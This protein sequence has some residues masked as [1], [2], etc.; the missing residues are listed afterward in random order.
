MEDET[1]VA[2]DIKAKLEFLGYEVT[3]LAS[4]GPEALEMIHKESPDLAI[5]DIVLKGAMDG[6]EVARKMRR[7]FNIPF[8]YLTALSDPNTIERAKVTEPFGY[9][10]K[11]FEQNELLAAIEMAL[12]KHKMESKIRESEEKYRNLFKNAVEG[13]FQTTTEGR[14]LAANP[15]MARMLGYVSPEDLIANRTDIARQGYVLPEKREE[16]MVLLEKFGEVRGFEL[17]AYRQDRSIVWLSENVRLVRDKQGKILFYEGTAQ[18]ISERKRAEE[19]LRAQ[20]DLALTVGKAETFEEGMRSCL[21]TAISI[22]EMDCGGVYLRDESSG[23]LDLVVHQGLSSEFIARASHYEKDEPNTQ[24][25]MAGKPVYTEHLRLGVPLDEVKRQEGLRAIALIPILHEDR[26]IGCMNI[27]SH[28]L[29]EVPVF[30]RDV[31]ETIAAQVSNAIVRLQIKDALSKSE[32]R[33]KEL[34]DYAPVAYHILN[35]EGIIIRAN[36]TEATM[37]GYQVQEMVGKSIFDFILPEHRD[38]AQKR[39]RQKIQGRAV[40]RAENR[41][42]IRKDGSQIFVVIDDVLERDSQGII[43]GIKSTMVDITERKRAEL[44]YKAIVNT[45]MD[46]FWITDIRGRFLDV[47]ET[48]CRLIGYSREE[49]LKMKISDVEAEEKPE[50]T[51]RRI[52]KIMKVGGDRFVTRHRRKDG[53]VID[54]EVSVNYNRENR[55]KLFVFLRDITQRKQMEEALAKYIGELQQ[56]SKKMISV[57]EAERLNISH[58]LHDEMGQ[59]LTMLRLNIASLRDILAPEHIGEIKKKIADADALTEKL[60]GQIHEL[61][62]DLRPHMLDDLGLVPTLRWY[63]DRMSRRLNIRILFTSKN[64]RKRLDSE[65]S[66]AIFRIIQEAMT[67]V[68]KYARAK[69]VRI[70]LVQKQKVIEA[71]IEDDGCGFDQKK[72]EKRKS[73]ARGIGLFSMKE[74]AAL[75]NGECTI[76]SQ[77]GKGTRIHIRIP[78]RKA[79]EKN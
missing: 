44:E 31:L 23:A 48:Y 19:L 67:N 39:F 25:V 37:L 15:A 47:N 60:L 70:R 10:I 54:I 13:I 73:P 55:D 79:G 5:I 49:L 41:V 26:V 14:F 75:L 34:W 21:E 43:T 53:K 76:E 61:T 4:T 28:T 51:A 69:K 74:R 27:S 36:Q 66:T 6:I 78:W 30:A 22:S 68:V 40:P 58:E 42:Y 57:Q 17:Q 59:A 52:R 16:F 62:L 1:L 7:D 12:Y 56:L 32:A 63:S 11:P 45:A 50:E 64:W 33:Y 72:I 8:L 24:L 46:G 77:P 35:T 65:I 2:R 3:G 20:R 18:D 9:I 29:P 71:L 38:E